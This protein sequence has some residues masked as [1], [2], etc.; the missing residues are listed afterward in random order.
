MNWL[1][2]WRLIYCCTNY[3]FKSVLLSRN[4]NFYYFF[5]FEKFLHE[6]FLFLPEVS[7]YKQAK[8]RP[9]NTYFLPE[10]QKILCWWPSY[11][12][13]EGNEQKPDTIKRKLSD[14]NLVASSVISPPLFLTFI[15]QLYT[16][17]TELIGLNDHLV[18]LNVIVGKI[19]T[20]LKYYTE[21][22]VPVINTFN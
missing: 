1:Y 4:C 17:L 20:N 18:L 16:R 12:Y 14:C 5:L 19:A 21:V 7:W 2:T 6:I 10:L 11:T 22:I 3:C 13:F 15:Q 8:I 9:C